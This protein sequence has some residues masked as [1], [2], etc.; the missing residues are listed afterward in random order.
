MS[1]KSQEELS[2]REVISIERERVI[3]LKGQNSVTVN[4]DPF[5]STKRSPDAPTEG[6]NS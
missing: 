4:L 3:I 1:V 6:R 5:Q 2:K